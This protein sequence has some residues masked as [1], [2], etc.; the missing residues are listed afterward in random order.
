MKGRVYIIRSK[1]T[2]DVYIGST[3][4]P[5]NTRFNRHRASRNAWLKDTGK[6]CSSYVI[7]SFDDAY[8]ELL[9][10]V[11]FD[12]KDVLLERE[13]H[14]IRTMICV[15]KQVPN[16]TIKEWVIDNKTALIEKW[17]TYREEHKEDRREYIN[18]NRKH[19]NET[20][21]KWYDENREEINRKRREYRKSKVKD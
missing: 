3:T 18:E 8:I 9:E 4:S 20:T 11:E 12:T 5:L 1:K 14:Y 7:L 19:I 16:R 10:E 15:N 2:N 17:K 21:R 13:A 6:F